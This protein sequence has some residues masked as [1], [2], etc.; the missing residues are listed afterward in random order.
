MR[1]EKKNSIFLLYCLFTLLCLVSITPAQTYCTEVVPQTTATLEAELNAI[2]NKVDLKDGVV[3]VYVVD[4]ETGREIFAYN[5]EKPLIPASCNKLLTTSAALYYLG[6]EYCYKTP[7]AYTGSTNGKVL[8]GDIVV[9]GSG[10]PTIS[11]RFHPKGNKDDVVWVFRRWAEKLKKNGIRK[12]YGNIIGDDDFFDDEYF[13]KGWYPAERGEWYCA[14]ISALSFNDNCID[15]HWRGAGKA[16][17]PALFKLNPPTEYVSFINNVT[18]VDSKNGRLS[19]RYHREDKSNIIRAEGTIPIKKKTIGWATVYNPTRYFV[20]VL[21]E[22]LEEEGIIVR[23]KPLDIDELEDKTSIRKELQILDTYISPPMA[24]IIKVIN[25]RSQNFYA[26]QVLKT[27]GKIVKGE[28]SFIAGCNAVIEFFDKEKIFV[29][30]TIMIDG[31]G[32][33]R[34]NRVSCLQLVKIFQYMAQTKDAN[35]FFD[36][37]PRGGV[38]G[39][40]A[41]RFQ[42]TAETRSIAPRILGKTGTLGGVN[43]LAGV[44]TTQGG[45]KLY[46]AIIVNA[47]NVSSSTRLKLIDDIILTIARKKYL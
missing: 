21:K 4:A 45:Q 2:I 25:Q 3:G 35:I 15:I 18:T 7:I 44:V 42:A 12:I 10:D 17:Q 40:L 9:I 37:L 19:L 38:S 11:G 14:E 29:P 30:G 43:S 6:S 23:G 41:R 47:S 28:G 32:L 16:G 39:T 1:A 20:T 24:S 13:G 22:T 5:P 8:N 33:S 31:S 36:S 34:L 27:I 26:D 46:Y